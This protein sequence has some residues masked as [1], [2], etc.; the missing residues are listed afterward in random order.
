MRSNL[1][2]LILIFTSSSLFAQTLSDLFYKRDSL[3][4]A[5]RQFVLTNKDTSKSNAEK[6]NKF[7]ELEIESNPEAVFFYTEFDTISEFLKVKDSLISNPDFNFKEVIRNFNFIDIDGDGDLDIIYDRLNPYRD[8]QSIYLY[9]NND[10]I[11]KRLM[12][13]GSI[14][15]NIEFENRKLKTINT[16]SW[17]SCME[18][19]D[20]YWSFTYGND[21][22]LQNYY[23][24]LPYKTVL[25][26]KITKQKQIET[27]DSVEIKRN[28]LIN[29]GQQGYVLYQTENEYFVEF[30]GFNHK[31]DAV[32]K[33]DKMWTWI[34]KDLVKTVNIK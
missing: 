28:I 16:F 15:T 20:H 2:I 31:K 23:L 27:I 19:F 32:W 25:P 26:K 11:Y 8:H 12:I 34:K 24:V 14:I 6:L 17:S 21:T 33:Y 5:N 1:F 10:G 9:I 29:K 4:I 13:P 3:I 7:I 22:I 30:V 18:P